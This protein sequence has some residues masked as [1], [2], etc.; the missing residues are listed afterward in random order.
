ML[1]VLNG[2]PGVGKLTIGQALAERLDAR[3]LDNH[4][5]YNVAFALT[6]FRSEAFYK[7]VRDVQ[8]IA[9]PLIRALPREVPVILTDILTERS[10][11][12]AE[13]WKRIA[14]LAADRGPL[15]MVHLLCDL[16]ENRRRI[17]SPERR[18]K[19]KPQDPELATRNHA[20]GAALSGATLERCLQLDVTAL[21][22]P[23]AARIIADWVGQAGPD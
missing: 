18:A 2:Y 15:F 9:D 23:E 10:S 8:G 5:I 13:L 16:E 20:G 1:I 6:E 21:A 19:R 4:S 7:A 22:A 11:R 3:L 12:S 14:A 17:E